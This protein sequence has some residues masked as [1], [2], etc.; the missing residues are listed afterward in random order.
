MKSA[1][2][3][4]Y[5]TRSWQSPARS[6]TGSLP[7]Y[8]GKYHKILLSLISK[9]EI[10]SVVDIGC[11]DWSL[12]SGA[13]DWSAAGIKYAGIDVVPE[14]VDYLNATHASPDIAFCCADACAEGAPSADLYIIKDV[15]QHLPNA[16]IAQLMQFLERCRVALITN[17]I[18]SYPAR[19]PWQRYLPRARALNQ[20]IPVGGWRCLNL[21]KYPF[22]LKAKL[23][24]RYVV[25]WDGTCFMKDVLVWKRTS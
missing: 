6:G 24:G 11:G 7:E 16:Q 18:C 4:I 10:G 12:Y 19:M 15:L 2:Q 21:R 23:A 8:N 20:D 3:A 13:F 25:E 14:L 17:D 9:Y 5:Q 1:F 22:N